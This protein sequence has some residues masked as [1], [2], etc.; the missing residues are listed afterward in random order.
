MGL[1][2]TKIE[3]VTKQEVTIP[4]TVLIGATVVNFSRETR[5]GGYVVTTTVT[6]GYDTPW[7]QVH[8]LLLRAAEQ[9]AGVR[10]EPKP[11]VLQRSLGDFY[12]EYR[13]AFAIERPAERY[14]VLSNLHAEIQDAF[15]EFGVQIMSPHFVRQPS[16]PVL[17]PKQLWFA[18]PS[19]GDDGQPAPGASPSASSITT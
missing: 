15:N 19:A 18:A 16:Q 8:A 17:V 12:V 5:E 6:I 4:N 7:R 10:R 13:L 14:L 3:T 9:T 2:S 11:F 1:L